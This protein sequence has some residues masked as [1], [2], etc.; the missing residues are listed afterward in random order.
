M[1][2]KFTGMDKSKELE[3]LKKRQAL[4]KVVSTFP[5]AI[6]ENSKVCTKD[7][8]VPMRDF[9]IGLFSERT[10]RVP[11]HTL[12][13]HEV[14]T[15]FFYKSF[16]KFSDIQSMKYNKDENILVLY[17]KNNYP[18]EGLI[19]TK[20]CYNILR[21]KLTKPRDLHVSSYYREN[22]GNTS[23][24]TCITSKFYDEEEL[25]YNL[26][27][28]DNFIETLSKLKEGTY[29]GDFWAFKLSGELIGTFDYRNRVINE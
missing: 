12:M 28:F 25:K 16:F 11:G 10:E 23:K 24:D 7:I 19:S 9:S 15:N 13:V 21:F 6:I 22:N 26:D 18:Y 2:A 4:T 5:V 8:E 29:I 20:L 14:Y 17:L 1:R 3:A 27:N